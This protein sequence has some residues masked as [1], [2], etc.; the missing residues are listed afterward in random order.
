MSSGKDKAKPKPSTKKPGPST[1][2][3]APGTPGTPLAPPAA[4]GAATEHPTAVLR[5]AAYDRAAAKVALE[6]LRPRLLAIPADKVSVPRLDVRTAAL[7]ALGVH[8]YVTGH[9]PIRVRFEKLH[10]A[11]EFELANLAALQDAA[12]VVLLT[13][14][15]AEEA[16]AFA[17]DIKV[18]SAV[19]EEAMGVERR[20]QDLLEYKF[21]KDPEIAPLLAVLRPGTGY[22]DLAADL[23]GYA[24]I[25][26]RRAKEVASDTT[27]Y[28][29]TDAADAHRL[30]GEILSHLSA[31]TSPRAREAYDTLRRAWTLLLQIY[32]EVS[33]SGRW[34]LRYDPRR[35]E[36]FPS[37][38]AAGRPGGGR[39]PKKPKVD[40]ASPPEK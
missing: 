15:A 13:H 22:R 34:L 39:P 7:S 23:I 6:A 5:P 3:K 32:F 18:P 20:M 17:T 10:G 26:E 25:Y 12:F 16:G 19:V 1:L 31:S 4:L 36:R 27:N 33:E 35:E 29:S 8:A 38:F 2:A 9:A 14:A 24:G 11:G 30:A 28:R 40:G 21:K 37:L